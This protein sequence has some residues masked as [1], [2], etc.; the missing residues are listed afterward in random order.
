[1]LPKLGQAFT[2][3]LGEELAERRL[4]F[5]AF[6]PPVDARERYTLAAWQINKTPYKVWL[7]EVM[8]QQTQVTT[9]IPYF[10][11]FMARFPTVTD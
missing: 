9:V 2:L 1:L 11:R 5:T 7:S 10:E 8:L 6:T 4:V 3:N